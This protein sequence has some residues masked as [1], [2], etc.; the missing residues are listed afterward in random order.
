MP[1][2]DVLIVGEPS[3]APARTLPRRL[4]DA[5]AEAMGSSPGMTW[6]TVQSLPAAAYGED[7][8]DPAPDSLPVYVKVSKLDLEDRDALAA[9]AAALTRAIAASCGRAEKS[10]RLIYE[11][12]LKGR[13]AVGGKLFG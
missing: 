13:V 1:M 12:P 3:G 9:E 7:G 2:L 11:P 5:A 10:V 4:A 6:V 8:G